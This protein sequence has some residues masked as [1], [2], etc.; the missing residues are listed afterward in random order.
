MGNGNN[1]NMDLWH[2][3]CITDPTQTKKI[4]GKPY[5]GTSP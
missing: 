4:E 2:S 5:K 3:V 1:Q